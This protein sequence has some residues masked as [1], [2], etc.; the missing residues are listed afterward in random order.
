MAIEE[1]TAD[2]FKQNLDSLLNEEWFPPVG[3]THNGERRMVVIPADV[4]RA[5]HRASRK[6]FR[7]EELS[8]DQIKAIAESK[9]PEGFEHLDDELKND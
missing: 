8:E 3:I 5:M 9:M 6:V 1:M 7:V 4:F 2:E